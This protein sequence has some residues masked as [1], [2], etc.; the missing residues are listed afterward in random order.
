MDREAWHAA[1]HG[2]TES[3]TTEQLNWLNEIAHVCDNN[4]KIFKSNVQHFRLYNFGAG[5]GV[6]IFIVLHMNGGFWGCSVQWN[7]AM[8]HAK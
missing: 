8:R 5:V 7:N 3:D 6:P 1:V 2:V 4:S